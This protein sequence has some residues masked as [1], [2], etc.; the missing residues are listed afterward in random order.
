MASSLSRASIRRDSFGVPHIYGESEADV[1]FGFGYAQAEDH[2]ERMMRNIYMLTGRMAE[3][4]GEEFVEQDFELRRYVCVA[5]VR[6]R[7]G[8]LDKGVRRLVEAF[9]GGINLYIGERREK[10]P[11]WI[12][13]VDAFDIVLAHHA[14]NL[15]TWHLGSLNQR[16]KMP[17]DLP[18][19]LKEF[20]KLEGYS[21]SW[22]V[23]PEKSESGKVILFAGPH[24]G[25]SSRQQLYEAHLCGG[26]LDVAGATMFGVPFI[27]IGFNRNIAW[28]ITISWSDT[29]DVFEEKL[30]P[31]NARQYLYEG[32][33]RDVEVF[34]EEFKVRTP[35]GVKMV[36]RE[37]AY[38]HHGPI[39]KMEAD[40]AYT[41]L[42]ST[43][44][45]PFEFDELY[46]VNV[47]QNLGEFKEA[48]SG[49]R[50]PHNNYVYGD[51]EG[52][53][54]YVWQSRI[55]RRPTWCDSSKPLPGWAKGGEWNG[56]IPFHELPQVENPPDGFLVNCNSNPGAVAP[57]A[58]VR[59][60]TD[61][62]YVRELVGGRVHF[63]RGRRAEFLI[64]THEKIDFEEAR[65]FALDQYVIDCE[66]PRA[67]LIGSYDAERPSIDD[68]KGD[69]RR[70]VEL[71]REWDGRADVDSGGMTV[72]YFWT[73][74][75]E[76]RGGGGPLSVADAEI[77]KRSVEALCAAV[78]KMRKLYGNVNVKWG[79]V[80]VVERGGKFYPLGGPGFPLL[81]LHKARGKM[82]DG[83]LLSA[84]GQIY[85]LVVTFEEPIRAVSLVPFG[86]SEDPDS[87]HFADQAPLV[88]R[89][90]L[91]PLAFTHG[92]VESA[93]ESDK[94]VHLH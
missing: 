19:K 44:R 36:R 13:P 26:G 78:E 46:R 57:R 15:C 22:V 30:N 8:R 94:Q 84:F 64:M 17:G 21:N 45:E 82:K 29:T 91:K 2:L 9:A 5:A 37:M 62:P 88:S 81:G 6:E 80:Q 76:E 56:F 60:G 34:E 27:V 31:G 69:V 41:I 86:S 77:R 48:I 14:E 87:P 51:R 63:E 53:I 74:E 92:Q 93:T 18:E 71:V 75:M 83:K 25:F 10:L 32:E 49:L 61:D 1:L 16:K 12:Q 79:D 50:R 85:T 43:W 20:I 90:E 35:D 28:G 7:Y 73:V 40:R 58:E 4:F 54:Y 42:P 89:R 52:N 39:V 59:C 23:G 55:P 33:W 70:A 72:F 24:I 66:A 11:D 47:A 65:D 67:L 38:T 3:A 68:P